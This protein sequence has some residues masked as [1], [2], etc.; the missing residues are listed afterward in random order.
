MIFVDGAMIGTGANEHLYN[1]NGYNPSPEGCAAL[2]EEIAQR[3]D[4][5]FDLIGLG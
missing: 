1:P 4:D 5:A 3:G 2:G